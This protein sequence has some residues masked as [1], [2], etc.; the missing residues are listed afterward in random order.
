MRLISPHP[1]SISPRQQG[2]NGSFEQAS[3]AME[4]KFAGGCVCGEI[5]Y[6]CRAE[7]IEEYDCRC[8]R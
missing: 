4:R 5:S 6:E 2:E 8:N 7:P 3:E 1:R